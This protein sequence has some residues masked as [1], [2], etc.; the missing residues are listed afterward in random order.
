MFLKQKRCGR[1]KGRGC[2]DGCP[3]RDYITKDELSSPTI[4]LY[5]LMASCV[6]DE[7]DSRH[8][9]T[10]DI[11]GVFLQGDWPQ[12]EHP[13]YIKFTRIMVDMICQ[14]NPSYKDKIIWSQDGKR[15]F[16][17]SELRKAVYGTLLAAVIFYNKLTKHLFDQ[18]FTMNGYDEYTFNKQVKG[19]QLTVQFHVDDLK[20]SHKDHR[21]LNKFVSNLKKEFGQE[22][23]L[24]ECTGKV[25]DYLGMT[26]DYSVPGK[27]VFTMFDYLE[28]IIVEAP[29]E[30]KKG[31][32]AYLANEKLFKLPEVSAQLSDQK[33]DLF[34]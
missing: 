13:G 23:E 7:L 28:D 30:L 2:A 18:G 14:I 27:V 3:Q 5:A 34:H 4:S 29:A 31:R 6:L 32:S 9:I 19:E 8:V 11:P 17:Y 25:H 21:V 22:A 10:I 16:L 26:I 20:V 15:K 1:V 12:N 33:S 24:S